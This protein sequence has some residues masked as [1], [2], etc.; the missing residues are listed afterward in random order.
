MPGEPATSWRHESRMKAC[1]QE[2]VGLVWQA[3][4]TVP[5]QLDP[6]RR[7]GRL[8]VSVVEQGSK[9]G[10]KATRSA[11]PNGRLLEGDAG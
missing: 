11:A 1:L 8:T 2:A 6:R 9:G 4:P 3:S 10:L 7:A 5:S